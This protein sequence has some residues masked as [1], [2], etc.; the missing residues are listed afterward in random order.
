[1]ETNYFDAGCFCGNW[2]FRKLRR[3]SFDDLLD[4]HR[5][6][7]FTGGLVSNLSS[8]L[9]YDPTEGDR[10]LAA[11]IKGTNYTLA[12]TVNPAL[13]TAAHTAAKAGELYAA[14]I[15]LYPCL[16][17][18]SIISPRVQD[19][20]RA[21]A[22]QDIPV[23]ITAR[24]EDARLSLLMPQKEVLLTECMALAEKSRIPS[25]FYPATTLRNSWLGPQM[26]CR[27]MYGSTSPES[28]KA[29]S[30]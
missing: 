27:K 21:A 5:K 12:M 6:N 16:H 3:S 8:V 23:I 18:Y 14:A 9:Y 25:C 10:D 24:V 2:P 20:C 19:I 15:R 11:W 17:P 28:I 22:E 7:G 29:C 1:M 4:E 26:V 30:R 13:Q